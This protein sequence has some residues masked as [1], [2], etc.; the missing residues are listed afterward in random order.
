MAQG[1]GPEFKPSIVKKRKKLKERKPLRM[2]K[3][4]NKK[5]LLTFPC[6]ILVIP[7]LN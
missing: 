6:K 7:T 2:R 5:T 4:K 3:E 1:L